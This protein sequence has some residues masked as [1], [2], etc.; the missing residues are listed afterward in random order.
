[1]ADARC[2]ASIKAIAINAFTSVLGVVIKNLTTGMQPGVYENWLAA[3]PVVALGA[4][5]GVFVVNLIGRKP[6]LLFV[7]VLCVG[8]FIWT[9]Y[10][11]RNAL[12]LG[13]L[14]ASVAAVGVFLL[15]FEKLRAWGAVLVGERKEQL[16]A[17][18]LARRSRNGVS[19][20]KGLGGKNSSR[21]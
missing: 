18:K 12:G 11:E 3:A 19:R 15:G 10:N 21:R 4:P 9:C 13:G 7:A 16:A 6:T 2:R 17:L 14:I 20:R 5:L 8:Q 1:L